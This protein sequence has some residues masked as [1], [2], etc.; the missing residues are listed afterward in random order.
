MTEISSLISFFTLFFGIWVMLSYKLVTKSIFRKSALRFSSIVTTWHFFIWLSHM[1]AFPLYVSIFVMLSNITIITIPFFFICLINANTTEKRGN[2]ILLQ[3]ILTFILI[4]I[5]IFITI[6]ELE[7]LLLGDLMKF[8][9]IREF[10]N[11]VIVYWFLS[12]G[13]AGFLKIKDYKNKEDPSHITKLFFYSFTVS[14]CV[15]LAGDFLTS[16]SPIFLLTKNISAGVLLFLIQFYIFRIEEFSHLFKPIRIN[17]YPVILGIVILMSG[18]LIY[19]LKDKFFILS[20]FIMNVLLIFFSIKALIFLSKSMKHNRANEMFRYLSSRLLYTNNYEAVMTVFVTEVVDQLDLE[21]AYILFKKNHL[22][23]VLK[24]FNK[25]KELLRLTLDDPLIHFFNR[26]KGLVQYKKIDYEVT[27]SIIQFHLNPETLLFAIHNKNKLRGILILIPKKKKHAFTHE[28]IKL[29]E[30][31]S[32][33]TLV[34]FNRI[35]NEEALITR[36]HSLETQVEKQVKEIKE[37]KKLEKELEMAS[38]IQKRA[39]PSDVPKLKGYTINASFYPARIVSGD[40]YDFLVFSKT[41]IGVVIADII[42]K[43]IPAAFHMMNLKAIVQQHIHADLSPKAAV[44][45]LN[46]ALYK[47]HLNAKSIPLIYGILDTKNKTF[48][49]TN[50]G[51]LPGYFIREDTLAPIFSNNILLGIDENAIY[52]EKT[53]HLEKGDVISLYTDGLEDVINKDGQKFGDTKIQT[54]LRKS[55]MNS[56]H[57]NTFHEEVIR[58]WTYYKNNTAQQKD[59]MTFISIHFNGP[60]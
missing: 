13:I 22:S 43:G 57:S 7:I 38:Q 37:K 20:L 15:G 4:C 11:L 25:N 55:A 8:G 33:Q 47:D 46:K 56:T 48:T 42:G 17:M 40:Y 26:E 49:Y 51:H 16:F 18:P 41:Q 44:E 21:T 14:S 28:D 39:L 60:Y 52:N 30:T 31:V 45:N 23:F 3:G 29:L 32:K 27:T 53:I 9:S 6:A 10:W 35:S 58:S 19:Y 2:Y 34:V 59:D 54:C 5:F 12:V 36:N 1:T 24:P 50:A